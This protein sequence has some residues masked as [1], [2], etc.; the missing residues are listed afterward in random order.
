MLD[1][2]RN[3][4]LISPYF[5]KKIQLQTT[6]GDSRKFTNVLGQAGPV[7]TQQCSC[8]LQY[9]DFK[10]LSMSYVKITYRASLSFNI[11]RV[12]TQ[13]EC[14]ASRFSKKVTS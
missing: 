10:H 13:Q 12:Q 4:E 6:P 3:T 14:L 2:G 9:E 5:V 8:N 7:V 11:E 1:T